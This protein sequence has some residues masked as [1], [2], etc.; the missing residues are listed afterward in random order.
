MYR[1]IVTHSS[2]Y[3]PVEEEGEDEFTTH[4]IDVGKFE[5]FGGDSDF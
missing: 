4:S 5:K 2:V 1:A 3:V